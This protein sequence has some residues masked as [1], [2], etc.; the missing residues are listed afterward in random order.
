M[1]DCSEHTD[2]LP[3][4]IMLKARHV[5]SIMKPRSHAERTKELL[6]ACTKDWPKKNGA[7]GKEY[8]F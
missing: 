1:H 8:F 3:D 2:S 5:E 7:R 4:M 6:M